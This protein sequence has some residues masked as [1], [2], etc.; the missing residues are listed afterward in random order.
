VWVV[1]LVRPL[2]HLMQLHKVRMRL[3][4]SRIV[5]EMDH[6]FHVFARRPASWSAAF[7][8]SIFCHFVTLATVFG[9]ARSL[10]INTEF[11]Y[12]LVF[13]PVINIIAAMP[14]SLAGWGLQETVYVMFFGPVG[15]SATEAIT[16]SLVYR[17]CAAVLWSLPGGVVLMRRTDRASV[18]EVARAMTGDEETFA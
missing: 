6:A 13:V 15:V 7:G 12:F 9:F 14:V 18:E 17:V 3:A 16:L 8:I 1:A 10:G 2:R 4:N 5:R 11:H